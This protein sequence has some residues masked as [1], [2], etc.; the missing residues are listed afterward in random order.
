MTH[1]DHQGLIDVSKYPDDTEVLSF[2]SN[3]AKVAIAIFEIEP[4]SRNRIA[5]TKISNRDDG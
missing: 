2:A 4:E 5:V 1:A 3:A